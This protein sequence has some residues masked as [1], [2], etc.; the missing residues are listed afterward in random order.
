MYIIYDNNLKRHVG[1]T[2]VNFDVATELSPDYSLE[3]Y[4]EEGM[5][6]FDSYKAE[7]AEIDLANLPPE[8]IPEVIDEPVVEEPVIIDAE[9]LPTE[10]NIV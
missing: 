9:V 6:D 1:I 5:A 7:Q 4:S 8:I 2:E 10:E 3:E